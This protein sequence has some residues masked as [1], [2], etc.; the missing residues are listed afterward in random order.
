MDLT[1]LAGAAAL[2]LA[3]GVLLLVAIG[4]SE[5]RSRRGERERVAAIRQR[6]VEVHHGR[7]AGR[8]P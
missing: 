2:S 6:L 4:L 1:Y 7:A 3:L 8:V 5:V